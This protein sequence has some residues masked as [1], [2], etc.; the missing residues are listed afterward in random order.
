MYVFS[1][2]KVIYRIVP[3]VTCIFV[4]HSNQF[5][6]WHQVAQLVEHPWLEIE[7][8]WF[9]SQSGPSLFCPI[10]LHLNSVHLERDLSAHG[11]SMSDD[12]LFICIP[13]VPAVQLNTPTARQ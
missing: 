8:A 11:V 10:Q 3:I 6:C 12:G 7:G 2:R 1:K 5:D 13:A 9:K 4:W